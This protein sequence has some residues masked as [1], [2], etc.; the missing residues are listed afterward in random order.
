MAA[1]ARLSSR[2]SR[3]R[4]RRARGCSS[5]AQNQRAVVPTAAMAERLARWDQLK[6]EFGGGWDSASLGTFAVRVA[7]SGN[8]YTG[9][10]GRDSV[11]S[12]VPKQE[13]GG[14]VVASVNGALTELDRPLGTPQ[15]EGA[16]FDVELFGF[17]TEVGREVFWHSA[18]HCL[19]QVRTAPTGRRDRR[20]RRT[21]LPGGARTTPR[22]RRADRT[23]RRRWRSTLAQ[24]PTRCSSRSGP[25]SRTRTAVAAS[26][27]RCTPPTLKAAGA[28]C[29]RRTSR[30][31]SR[32]CSRR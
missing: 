21:P 8:T 23:A 15:D 19:G 24:R 30:R 1:L 13:L 7:A 28:R 31:C 4:P 5:A 2:L 26:S 25:R 29:R 14:A 27:T 6:A 3:L 16:A 32:S 22:P 12:L 18:A 20:G 17:D 10:V 9:V 11:Q